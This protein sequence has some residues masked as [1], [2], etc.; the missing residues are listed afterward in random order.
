[1]KNFLS[2]R[3]FN[4]SLLSMLFI[5]FGGQAQMV[6]LSELSM[7][8]G[9]QMRIVSDFLNTST[10]SFLNDGDVYSCRNF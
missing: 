4:Y 5:V 9:T 7:L 6:H 2:K 10:G 8:P 3:T 1:M